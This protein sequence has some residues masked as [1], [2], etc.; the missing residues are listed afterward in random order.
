MSLFP[1]TVRRLFVS[2]LDQTSAQN[3]QRGQP[4]A[5]ST[6]PAI[7]SNGVGAFITPQSITTFPGAVLVITILSGAF[8]YFGWAW[9]HNARDLTPLI[10][11]LLVGTAVFLVNIDDQ[12]V[13]PKSMGKWMQAILAGV[14][15]TVILFAAATSAVAI[16]NSGETHGDEPVRDSVQRSIDGP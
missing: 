4:M 8:E 9:H 16:A 7:G 13:R 5:A 11:S 15:N 1:S 6:P 14:A 10:P 3:M 2:N 12:S